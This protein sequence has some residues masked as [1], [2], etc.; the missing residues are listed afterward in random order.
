[1]IS[2]QS[3]IVPILIL[4]ART[5]SEFT[6]TCGPEYGRPPY[7]DCLVAL[8]RFSE[9]HPDDSTLRFEAARYEV[10]RPRAGG[11]GAT[12]PEAPPAPDPLI[13]ARD[14]IF[15]EIVLAVENP[16][17]QIPT[18]AEIENLYRPLNTAQDAYE[19]IS[20]YQARDLDLRV[21]QFQGMP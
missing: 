20:A 16:S 8:H 10:V 3:C 17:R 15:E 1:M 18:L 7:W 11:A 19:V 13:A 14:N 12:L 21:S 5:S 2:L 6:G 4:V 9:L